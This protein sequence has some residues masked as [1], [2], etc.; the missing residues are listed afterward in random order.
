MAHWAAVVGLFLM[1]A[2]AVGARGELLDKRKLLERQTFWDNRDWDWYERNIPFFESPDPEIDTTYYYRW[3]LVTKHLVYGSPET[4]YAYTEFIDRPF[5]SGRYGA[6]SCPAGHQLYEVRW[7]KQPEYAQD[8]ARYWFRTEGAQPRR[9]STWLADSV[10]AVGMVQGEG[11]EGKTAGGVAGFAVDLLDDLIRNYEAWERTHFSKEVGLFW[12]NGHDEG[13]EY[14]IS[15]RQTQDILRGAPGYRPSMNAYMY[16]DA[17]AIA[18][19]ARQAGRAEVAAVYEA[20]AAGLKERLQKLTWDPKREFFFH[21]FKQ[22]ERDKEG[23]VVKALTKV[24]ETGRFAGSPHGREQI[25]YVPWQFNLPDEGKGYDAAWKFLMDPQYFFAPFGPTTAERNDPM[26][27]VTKGCCWWS[28]Q[29]WPYATTQTLVA[30]ANLLNNYRQSVVTKEDY[31]KLLRVYTMTHRKNGK[32]YIAEGANPDTG[33]WEGYDSYNHSEHYFHS[34]YTDLIITGLCGLRPR[35]DD[36][37]EIN[38]LIPETWAYFCLD[39]VGYR[40]RRVSIVWD[41][42]GERYGKGA[43]LR[44]IVDGKALASSPTLGRLT[45]E[46]PPPEARKEDRAPRLLNYA[47]NNDGTSFPRPI[48]SHTSDVSDLSKV[49]DGQY[50]YHVAPPNRWTAEGSASEADW[51]GVDFGIERAVSLVNVFPLDDGRTVLPP[52]KIVIES[53][54]GG[55]WREVPG[56]RRS[57]STP[58]G[59]RANAIGFPAIRT[60]KIRA[61]LTHVTGAKTGL[62]EFEAW[63]PGTLPVPSAPPPKGNFALEPGVTATASFTSRFDEAAEAVD[64]KVMYAANPRNRWTSYESKEKTDWLEIDLAAERTIGRLTLHLY[65]DRGGVRAPASYAVEAW[66]G[67]A[68]KAVAAEQRD[69]KRPTGGRANEITFTPVTTR[70]VR[71]TFTHAGNA[72]SGVTEVEVWKE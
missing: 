46:M 21:V 42:T 29:S 9:Y 28:G 38:P 45:A 31:A 14:N 26:F 52:T 67:A 13:M 47:V 7:L 56:Q 11:T 20:K 50:W 15:S 23:N 19:I 62:S 54:D 49:I 72:R 41:K 35:A 8:Y 4:G 5:W 36:V 43:G 17:L 58:R 71:I 53:W 18:K 66:D 30:M 24:H 59:R 51:V 60:S 10:W 37:L 70:K 22:D 27:L 16:A 25:G 69:P 68:F 48:A 2:A 40:G 63:G 12:Q 34:G 39:D 57:P 64:G 32:P 3:E 6:I 55:A 65:D 33:S 1:G 44:V 61:V